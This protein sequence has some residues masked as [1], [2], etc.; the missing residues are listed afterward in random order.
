M[1]DPLSAHQTIGYKLYAVT[2]LQRTLSLR[3]LT[4]GLLKRSGGNMELGT[5]E[6]LHYFRSVIPGE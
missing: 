3:D 5:A 6:L 4:K 2:G 1:A